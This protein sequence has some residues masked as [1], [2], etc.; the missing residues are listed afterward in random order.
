MPIRSL[1]HYTIW[2]YL[3]I[4]C[5]MW[6]RLG[7]R[8]KHR[9]PHG[10]RYWNHLDIPWVQSF[11]LKLWLWFSH[12]P[13]YCGKLQTNIADP[14]TIVVPMRLQIPKNLDNCIH[15]C[16]CEPFMTVI[17]KMFN[18]VRTVLWLRNPFV[19]KRARR[20]FLYENL[21][22]EILIQRSNFHMNRL[23]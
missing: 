10:F 18:W 16:S 12:N 21:L 17:S 1:S 4:S 13:W 6:V 20:S 15:N 11:K 5:H 19:M 2:H 23:E 9:N 22:I 3:I 14:A 8:T 7:V